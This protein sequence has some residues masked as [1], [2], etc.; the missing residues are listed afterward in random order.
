MSFVLCCVLT[1]AVPRLVALMRGGVQKQS[2]ICLFTDSLPIGLISRLK[3]V[4][5]SFYREF[6]YRAVYS[7]QKSEHNAE[8]QAHGNIY[9]APG[10]CGRSYHLIKESAGT[11]QV[12]RQAS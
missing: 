1:E 5:E 8:Q 12:V 6:H 4:D 3:R 10:V 11:I 7:V 9:D 2:R